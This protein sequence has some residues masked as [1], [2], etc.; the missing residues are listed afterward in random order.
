M[1]W[2]TCYGS[3]VWWTG[4]GIDGSINKH[5]WCYWSDDMIDLL[6]VLGLMDWWVHRVT[7]LMSTVLI[8]LSWSTDNAD[9]TDATKEPG[10]VDSGIGV[11]VPVVL[12]VLVVIAIATVCGLWYTNCPLSIKYG[13]QRHTHSCTVAIII[14]LNSFPWFRVGS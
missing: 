5:C 9:V 10:P 11:E 3:L 13:A 14:V 12:M 1:S 7:M 2:W 8:D 6:W 4:W